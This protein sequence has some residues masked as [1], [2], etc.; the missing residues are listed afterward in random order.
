VV[1]LLDDTLE[2]ELVKRWSWDK[3]ADG[4]KSEN[5]HRH[6]LPVAEFRDI[7]KKH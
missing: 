1:K 7:C 6:L 3:E 4:P 5:A 2:D